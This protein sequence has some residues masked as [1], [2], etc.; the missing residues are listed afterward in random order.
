MAVQ[1]IIACALAAVAFW[2]SLMYWG[3]IRHGLK[4]KALLQNSITL[5]SKRILILTGY[6]A[7]AVTEIL[8][9][10]EYE[11]AEIR[12]FRCLIL[13]YLLL[14]LAWVDL[15]KRIIPNIVVLVMFGVRTIFLAAECVLASEIWRT[16][17]SMALL[18]L[19][20][21]FA[22]MFVASALTR[23]AVGMGDVKLMAMVGYFVGFQNLLSCLLLPLILAS[24]VGIVLVLGKKMRMKDE[25]AF[26]PYV[27]VGVIG[28]LLLGL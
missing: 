20:I 2:L 9:F 17:V 19:A 5:K 11:F 25:L 13:S 21:G 16:T 26:A 7:L 23:N 3:R 27:A 15:K 12:S 1:I 28:V 10:A 6:F 22:V 4:G 24:V 14:L 18:G 8:V